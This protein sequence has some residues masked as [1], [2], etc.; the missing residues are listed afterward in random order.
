MDFLKALLSKMN[1]NEII[2]LRKYILSFGKSEK[3]TKLLELMLK[4]PEMD[5][6]KLCFRIYKH[7]ITKNFQMLKKRLYDRALE[8]LMLSFNL[9]SENEE[10]YF[11][12]NINLKKEIIYCHFLKQ[13]GLIDELKAELDKIIHIARAGYFTEI[14]LDALLIYRS[15]LGFTHESQSEIGQRIEILIKNYNQ[16]III[17]ETYK[18]ALH[19][20]SNKAE[21]YTPFIKYVESQNEL[22]DPAVE[23]IASPKA[24]YF[25][26]LIQTLYYNEVHNPVKS[27]EYADL[28][29]DLL[30]NC[31]AISTN[32][33][34]G[35]CWTWKGFSYLKLKNY[36]LGQ[37]AFERA[38]HVYPKQR[39]TY[40]VTTKYIAITYF[41]QKD[42]TKAESTI[43]FLIEE[44]KNDKS[45]LDLCIYYYTCFLFIQGKYSESYNE[46][47]KID[48]L[49]DNKI[50]FNAFLRLIEIMILVELQQFDEISNK[51]ENL[52]K[53]IRRYSVEDCAEIE[54][55]K[56]CL[57]VFG[58]CEDNNWSWKKIKQEPLL[59]QFMEQKTNY[60]L[61]GVEL[62]RIDTWLKSK[63]ENKNYFDFI[64]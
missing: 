14:E 13:R 25:Y 7:S 17:F 29:L 56:D 22:F 15:L 34:I 48:L 64:V 38:I 58:K 12:T 33:K 45:Q 54:F 2:N 53:H 57:K 9:D 31:S 28:N 59:N 43:L 42:F 1:S 40:K 27:L 19:L 47:Q 24:Q 51:L 5:D 35:N 3:T 20:H 4:Y 30:E 37:D 23:Y 49:M 39:R 6:E 26:N 60:H 36:S 50:S 32:L 61:L 10:E 21:N 11:V 55:F 52:R 44:F 16:E 63:I 8:T 18:Q 46:W 41:F 62:I